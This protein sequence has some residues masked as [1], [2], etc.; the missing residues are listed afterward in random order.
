MTISRSVS[1]QLTNIRYTVAK[2]KGAY[3][4][5][6]PVIDIA[7]EVA[8]PVQV[9]AHAGHQVTGTVNIEKL[10]VVILHLCEQA[11]AQVEND[12][13]GI[14][15]QKDDHH[16]PQAF[17]AQL[18]DQ[19]YSQNRQQG[20]RISSHNHIVNETA[21]KGRVHQQQEAGESADA[22]G[23]DMAAAVRNIH[24]LPQPFD[25]LAQHRDNFLL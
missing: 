2:S 4:V 11:A 25:L 16:I 8:A 12:I 24:I 5:N 22:Q 18:D 21:G 19:H 10:H 6:D 20:I 1:F 7:E 9:S 3:R 15:F 17:P 14:L 13:L 23:D